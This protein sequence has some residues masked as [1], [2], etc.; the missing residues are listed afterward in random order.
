MRIALVSLAFLVLGIQKMKRTVYSQSLRAQTI[1]LGL[2]PRVGVGGDR[3]LGP[4][5]HTV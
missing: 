3:D 4:P 2:P 1:D 5:T